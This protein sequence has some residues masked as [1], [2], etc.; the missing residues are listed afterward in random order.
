MPPQQPYQVKS[1]ARSYLVP[2]VV[3]VFLVLALLIFGVWAFM[4]RADYKNNADEKIAA[5]VTVAVQEESTR[6]DNEFLEREKSPVKSFVG[7]EAYGTVRFDYPKTWSG[8]VLQ[9]DS[10]STHVNAYFHPNTVPDVGGETAYALRFQILDRTYDASLKSF[11][12]QTKT[13]KVKVNAYKPKNVSGITAV[14]LTGEIERG[15]QGSMVMIKLRDKTIQIWTESEVFLRDFDK[16]VL[17]TLKF[18]P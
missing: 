10:S 11:A 6:K 2:F 1:H 15:K 8:Y 9:K 17:E 14:R 5:A 13:G 16:F 3:S 7:P 18:I 4:E 12:S